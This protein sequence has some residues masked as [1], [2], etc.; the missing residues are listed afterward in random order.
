MLLSV[1]EEARRAVRTAEWPPTWY[2]SQSTELSPPLLMASDTGSPPALWSVER[3]VGRLD[4]LVGQCFSGLVSWSGLVTGQRT[5]RATCQ[6]ISDGCCGGRQNHQ[7]RSKRSRAT[8]VV[9]LAIHVRHR[10]TGPRSAHLLSWL[11]PHCPVGGVTTWP[12][13]VISPAAPPPLF[14]RR[15]GSEESSCHMVFRQLVRWSV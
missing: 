10:R 9:Y 12:Y 14:R 1:L 3:S 15:R 6:A 5:V 13:C 2:S 4:Q 11:C 7:R 8:R